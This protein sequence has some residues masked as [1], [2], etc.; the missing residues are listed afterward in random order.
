MKRIELTSSRIGTVRYS[1]LARD[2]LP[3]VVE[4]PVPR[5]AVASSGGPSDTVD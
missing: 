3:D 2:F 1:Q 4:K 5:P